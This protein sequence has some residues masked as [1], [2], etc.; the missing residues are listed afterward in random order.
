MYRAYVLAV[1][2]RD[3]EAKA[4]LAQN[5]RVDARHLL[6]Y[7]GLGDRERAFDALRRAAALDPW[8]AVTWM[9]RPEMALLRGDP[10]Y[11]EIRTQ[12]LQRR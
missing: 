11:D 3:E 1:L 2:G 8:R 6:V 5:S 12:L 4:L 9:Q 7:A 10:R